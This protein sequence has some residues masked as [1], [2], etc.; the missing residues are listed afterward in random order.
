ML[1]ALVK[2]LLVRPLDDSREGLHE[3]LPEN[4][5]FFLFF[6]QFIVLRSRAVQRHQMYFGGSVV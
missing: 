4:F 5:L 3:V 1:I 6:Y 2:T